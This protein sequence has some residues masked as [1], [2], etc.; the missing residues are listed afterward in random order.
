M[1]QVRHLLTT[2]NG[3]K[4]AYLAWAFIMAYIMWG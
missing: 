1:E 3:G 4:Y 2:M